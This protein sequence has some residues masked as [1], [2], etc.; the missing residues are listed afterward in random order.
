[1]V[2]PA[3]IEDE[4]RAELRRHFSETDAEWIV[5]SVAMMGW[6]NKAMDALGVP[7]EGGPPPPRLEA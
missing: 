6:L 1:M 2:V 4:D 5:L 7:L 3:A